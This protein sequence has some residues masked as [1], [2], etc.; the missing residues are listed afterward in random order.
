MGERGDCIV[1]RIVVCGVGGET[2][3]FA[4]LAGAPTGRLGIWLTVEVL[5]GVRGDSCGE[6]GGD[7]S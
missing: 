4:L 2:F 1:A 7:T 5:A 3:L 6:P